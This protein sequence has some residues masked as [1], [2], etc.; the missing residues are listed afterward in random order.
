MPSNSSTWLLTI[1]SLLLRRRLVRPYCNTPNLI[2]NYRAPQLPRA[3]LI[4][5]IISNSKATWPSDT[6]KEE[7]K[8]TDGWIISCTT[9]KLKTQNSKKTSTE[10][11]CR[12]LCSCPTFSTP[13]VDVAW[14]HM[15]HGATQA[16][17]PIAH[18]QSNT[19][20]MHI[21]KTSRYPTTSAPAEA[22]VLA[23][24]AAATPNN[25]YQAGQ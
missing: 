9:T 5:T 15:F 3:P 21:T 12:R 11:Q 16:V 17:I 6:K 24:A 1:S 2:F 4:P 10:S 22:A 20:T 14:D 8:T 23:A 13:R 7:T 19:H 18:T 25:N